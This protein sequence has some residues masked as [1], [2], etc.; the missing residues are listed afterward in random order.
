MDNH[1][2]PDSYRPYGV[3]P[4]YVK[5]V[6]EELSHRLGRPVTLVLGN[7]IIAVRAQ[8]ALF[9]GQPVV[10]MGVS[11]LLSMKEPTEWADAIERKVNRLARRT[12]DV[13]HLYAEIQK[14]PSAEKTG[15]IVLEHIGDY[16][17]D[18]L[19]ALAGLAAND[20]TRRRLRR[21]S[22]FEALRKYLLMVRRRAR[23]GQTAA[24]WRELAQGAAR[25]RAAQLTG[26]TA[27]V[28]GGMTTR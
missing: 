8:D 4:E 21:A 25:E 22:N 2:L 11:P 23:N 27:P 13:K 6:E 10:V 15:T 14:S 24:M 16:D 5:K 18:F 20:R 26:P 19:E 17:D 3:V 28:Q 12:E 1:A 7:G 9:D